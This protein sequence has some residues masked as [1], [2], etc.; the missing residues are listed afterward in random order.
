MVIFFNNPFPSWWVKCDMCGEEGWLDKFFPKVSGF[1]GDITSFGEYIPESEKI[2][3]ENLQEEINNRIDYRMCSKTMTD[4]HKQWW[5]NSGVPVE[6]Q[7]FWMLGHINNKVI[8]HQDKYYNLEAYMIPKHGLNWEIKNIDYRL[9]DPP[10]GVGR[11]RPEPGIP[12]TFFISRPDLKEITADGTVVIVEG[13]KKAMVTAIMLGG[14]V[15]VLGV[16]GAMSWA[17][18]AKAVKE[19]ERV[20]VILDP[21]AEVAAAKLANTIGPSAIRLTLPTKIDDAI[22]LGMLDEDTLWKMV[23][24]YGRRQ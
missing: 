17:G 4:E 7:R 15:Q 18:V 19:V 10:L 22:I 13:S 6:W 2:E 11:Y 23:K 20:V 8:Y 5:T 3:Y 9:V 21:D 12:Q 24:L 1:L 14:A 16:P